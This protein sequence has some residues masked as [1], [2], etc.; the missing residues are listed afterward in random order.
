MQAVEKIINNALDEDIG[1]GDIT[2]M[3]TIPKGRKAAFTFVTR[4]DIV[5]CGLPVLKKIFAGMKCSVHCDEGSF[6]TAGARLFSISG[7]ARKI[8]ERERVAL[9]LIQRMSGIATLT[10]QYVKAVKGTGCTILDTRKTTPGLRVLEKYAVTVGGGKNHRMR[11]DDGILIKDNHISVAGS[12]TKAV[13]MALAAKH[14]KTIEV[15][16]DTISQVR[17][18]MSAGADMLLLDNMSPRLM[19]NI[20]KEVKGKVPLEASGGVNLK[21]VRKIAKTGV[22]YISVGAL[23]HSAKNVD[24]GLD[25]NAV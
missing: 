6:A 15:E 9:N 10:N 18:A 21:T 23:T 22:D 14:K 19:R 2:S 12:V 8:L 13:K 11:L 16:C 3:I 17:E 1:K 25:E 5:F 7:D 4:E 20:V 24:I